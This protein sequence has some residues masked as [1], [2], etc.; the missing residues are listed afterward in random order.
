MDTEEKIV[1]EVIAV[2][3]KILELLRRRPG[4]FVSGEEIS[5]G[6]GVSRT[7]VWKHIQEL[8]QAGYG[9]EAHSRRGYRLSETPDKLLPPEI[10]ARL[11]TEI[12]GRNIHYYDDIESTNNEAKRLAAEGCP[13][14]TLV[15]TEAQNAGRGRLSRGWF[16]PWGKGIWLSAVLRPPFS[17]QDAPQCTLMAAVAINKAIREVAGIDCG[18]K[19]PNDI[20]FQG[21][22]LVG[23]LTEM[24]AEMDA[25]NYIVLG[26]GIN[27]NISQSEFPEEISE[28]ATSIALAAGQK[29]DRLE[30]LGSILMHLEKIYTETIAHGFGPVLD[31]WRAQ[32]ITLGQT[33]DVIGLNR[34]FTGLALNI[35]HDG[36]LLVKMGD[37]V[38]RVLAGDVSIRP[39]AKME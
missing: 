19:W 21:R 34:K 18:I 2:R 13:E 6:L 33:V 12:L 23:I 24:S 16:S 37:T 11:T 9:I 4:E 15:V 1:R 20:L 8:K 10:H 25:I 27:V 17:P 3:T 7:A 14:G 5:G 28:T 22:K 32:S 39:S 30:L 29:I 36:A 35:D 31:E 26:M 38:E